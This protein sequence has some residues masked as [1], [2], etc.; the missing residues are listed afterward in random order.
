V[1]GVTASI[2]AILATPLYIRCRVFGTEAWAEV[3]NEAHPDSP[4]GVTRLVTTRSG[5]AATVEE[6]AWKDTIKT[7][8]EAFAAA[9]EGRGEYRFTEMELLHN[10][11]LLEAITTSS[12]DH[13]SILLR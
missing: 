9:V 8:L 13:R 12:Q 2:G 7:N 5:Q 11:E 10:V 4:S 3:V 1:S 6:F